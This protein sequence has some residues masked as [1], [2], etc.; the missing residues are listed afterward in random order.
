M[1]GLGGSGH[2]LAFPPANKIMQPRVY[3]YKITFEEVPYWYW[4][5]HKEKKFGELYLGS[6][7][8]HKWMW[9]FYTPRIQILEFF[10]FSEEGW[11]EARLV[12]D[13]LIR[14]DLNN[15]LCLNEGCGGVMSLAACKKGGRNGGKKAAA[16][17]HMERDEDGKSLHGRRLGTIHGAKGAKKTHSAKDEMGKSLHAVRTGKMAAEILHAEKD[18]FGRS[19]HAVKTAMKIHSRKDE[20]GRSLHSLHSF[21]DVHLQKDERG[22]SVTG[23]MG[24]RALHS[25]KDEFGRSIHALKS[26]KD[27]HEEKTPE[28]KS[29]VSVR[30]GKAAHREKD[31]NGKSVHGVKAGK[32]GGK[33]AAKIV[34]AQKWEDPDHPELGQH[35]PGTL[36]RM[37]KRR[38]L[39][40]GK[41]NRRKVG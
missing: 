25:E 32:V 23:V 30:G 35:S 11:K 24:A 19:V 29:A 38:D 33:A 9:E 34:N 36:T 17:L 18:E 10:P 20:K 27:I 39:P 3:T 28:G 8:T 14:P 26:F 22:K 6:P 13:R 12:E 21:K 7:I 40:S 16:K 4:G 1:K 37:Q 2:A 5:S 41:E 15:A 31:E